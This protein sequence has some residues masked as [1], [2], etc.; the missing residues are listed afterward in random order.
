VKTNMHFW[1]HLA[2]F[3]EWSVSDKYCRENQNTHFENRAFYEIMW[4]NIAQPGRPHAHCMLHTS[5][6]KYTFR[7]CKTAVPLQQWL[8]ERASML[9]YTY[10]A[11]LVKL[12]YFCLS[13]LSHSYNLLV[14]KPV[15]CDISLWF[16]TTTLRPFRTN[17]KIG[18]FFSNCGPDTS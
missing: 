15:Q 16:S 12:R 9:R 7:I 6:H 8:H 1:S 11:C 10:I 5:G 2:Q 14:M 17:T 13:R 3:L 4:K 18:T